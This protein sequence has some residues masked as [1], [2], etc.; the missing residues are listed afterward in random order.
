MSRK[1]NNAIILSNS[2]SSVI[3]KIQH[4]LHESETIYCHHSVVLLLPARK[5]AKPHPVDDFRQAGA[6][7]CFSQHAHGMTQSLLYSLPV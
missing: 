1:L 3:K 5:L 4:L 2:V 7:R 6:G